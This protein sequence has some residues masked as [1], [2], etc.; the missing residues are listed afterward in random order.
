[1]R[2]YLIDDDKERYET[3][4]LLVEKLKLDSR[5][6]EFVWENGFKNDQAKAWRDGPSLIRALTDP[7]A[8]ILLDIELKYLNSAEECEVKNSITAL[9]ERFVSIQD[10][11][12]AVLNSK[13]ISRLYAG[14]ET[15]FA[16][17]FLAVALAQGR[18]SNWIYI[19]SKFQEPTKYATTFEGFDSFPVVTPLAWTIP[20]ASNPAVDEVLSDF[21]DTLWRSMDAYDC[22]H[23]AW[24][25]LVRYRV[26]NKKLFDD[27][28]D[29]HYAAGWILGASAESRNE[30]DELLKQDITSRV[31]NFR[32]HFDRSCKI[33]NLE[34]AVQ[35][36]KGIYKSDSLLALPLLEIVLGFDAYS[37]SNA[38]QQQ[39]GYLGDASLQ[40]RRYP[41]LECKNNVS[42]GRVL[43]ALRTLQTHIGG[44]GGPATVSVTISGTSPSEPVSI[45]L[46]SRFSSAEFASSA[47][48]TLNQTKN[49]RKLN[50][51]KA[52]QACEVLRN[53]TNNDWEICL[54][55]GDSNALILK[56]TFE[57]VDKV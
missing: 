28:T 13:Y 15:S 23:A 25:R 40:C 4:N 22:A 32:S 50:G 35:V 20:Q 7:E 57:V 52:Y 45:Q 1:M 14:T 30:Q 33:T 12:K 37:T 55:K 17:Y 16:V 26:E 42:P 8:I 3:V 51:G 21:V 34:I 18:M 24:D 53:A 38:Y 36:L 54:S 48:N 5:L 29:R 49:M 11:I 19:V 46:E 47:A 9:E 2:F 44:E 31:S 27:G 43:M 41:C 56:G 6:G 39:S 10:R